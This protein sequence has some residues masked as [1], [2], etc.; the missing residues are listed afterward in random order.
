MQNKQVNGI[1]DIEV[2]T[3]KSKEH[4]TNDLISVFH[5][6]KEEQCPVFTEQRVWVCY[7]VS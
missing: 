2:S 5:F 3:V 6:Q 1:V 7:Y 4:L